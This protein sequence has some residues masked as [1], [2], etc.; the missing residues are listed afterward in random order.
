[1]FTAAVA[2]T[3]NDICIG[4]HTPTATDPAT[5]GDVAGVLGIATDPATAGD[6]ADTLII[7]PD[8]AT[9]GDVAGARL[10]VI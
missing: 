10:I 8:P 5:A 2:T 7:V 6:A 4:T 9:A 1:M 3:D